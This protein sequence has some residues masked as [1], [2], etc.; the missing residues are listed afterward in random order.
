MSFVRPETICNETRIVWD[1]DVSSL[2]YV[3]EGIYAV[4][5]YRRRGPVRTPGRRVGYAE[6]SRNEGGPVIHR[7]IFWLA[8]HDRDSEP[9]GC[10][11]SGAPSEAVDPRTV[12]PG[13]PGRLTERAWGG[14]V[15]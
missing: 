2:D 5:G 10:Y 4:A 6:V 7:R 9:D 1:E 8:E 12:R 11:A 15:A 3:R 14:V 13:V